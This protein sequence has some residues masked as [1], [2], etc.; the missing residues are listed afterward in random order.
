MKQVIPNIFIYT[1]DNCIPYVSLGSLPVKAEITALRRF[2]ILNFEQLSN[3][4][5]ETAKSISDRVNDRSALANQGAA[6]AF[7]LISRR[8]KDYLTNILHG[9]QW[10]RFSSSP[11]FDTEYF[12]QCK[13][14]F[15]GG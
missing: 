14:F 10:I 7:I 4:N 9:N 5:F 11:P 1:T 2:G 8:Q 13:I 12:L 6:E 3:E 15:L